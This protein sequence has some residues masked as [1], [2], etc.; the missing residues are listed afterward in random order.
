MRT[1]RGASSA[2]DRESLMPRWPR[3]RHERHGRAWS[4]G[5][6]GTYPPT[7]CGIATFTASLAAAVAP[8][9]SGW[10]FGV[11][12]CV[13]APGS[14]RH[15]VEVVAELV[16]GSASSLGIAAARL[17][18]FDAVVLQHEFGIFGGED[19]SDVLDL[20]LRLG[21][22]LVVVLHTVL[23]RP[24]RGQREIVERL[25]E[26][27]DLLVVQSRSARER[28]VDTYRVE[29]DRVRLVPHGA[30]PNIRSSAPGLGRAPSVLTWGLIGPGKGIDLGIE[31]IAH[32][33]DLAPQPRYVVLG[34]THPKIV[35]ARGDYRD[36]LV[37]HAN[38]LG[39]S[40]LVE[41][42][43]AYRETEAILSRVRKADIVLL[44]Y[45]SREQVVS[46]VLVEAIASGKPVV[47]TRFPHA[48]ELLGQGSGLLVPHDDPVAMA[49]ALRS[50]L[51]DPALARQMAAVA[52]RQAKPLFWDNVGRAYRGLVLAAAGERARAEAAA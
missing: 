38:R 45:R 51:T 36:E 40:G 18:Q 11:V 1:L 15:P 9:G 52:R 37:D 43:N 12:A 14:V 4:V 42:D 27:A 32:L 35:E 23:E 50:L 39:V 31:A 20:T 41:F 47:A 6:V 16:G 25:A 19:G 2:N 22:P 10:D 7:K 49:S 5:F 8:P 33:R 17:D 13:D 24:S 26:R 3:G 48:E 44:P 28:L 29:A 46:G 30:P 21:A 34:Q